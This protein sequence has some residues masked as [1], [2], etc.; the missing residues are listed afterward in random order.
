MA[1]VAAMQLLPAFGFNARVISGELMISADL[2][3]A[4]NIP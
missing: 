2:L 1:K 4:G 3:N